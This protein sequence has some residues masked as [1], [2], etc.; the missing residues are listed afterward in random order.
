MHDPAIPESLPMRMLGAYLAACRRIPEDLI[1]LLARISLAAT[2]WLS[3]QTKV[4]GFVLDPIGLQAQFGWPRLSAG[5]VDLFRDEYALPVLPPELAATMAATAE[6]VFPLLLLV[7]LGTRLS[8]TALLGMTLVIE[9]FVY[10]GAWP[11]HGLWAAAML[12]LMAHGPGRLSIDHLLHE[13][14]AGAA[15]S[16]R[17]AVAT[18]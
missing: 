2:F 12:Y 4:E 18:R 5:A 16:P 17:L 10:P 15:A 1:R 3:G 9:I 14:S 6:H 13:R 11:T 7:G 8:A